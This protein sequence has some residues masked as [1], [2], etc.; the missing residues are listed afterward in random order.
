MDIGNSR[1]TNEIRYLSPVPSGVKRTKIYSL[2]ERVR[3]KYDLV[4]GFGQHDMIS[5][6]GGEIVYVDSCDEKQTDS[7]T[8]NPDD[9][10]T[11][12][13]ATLCQG[14]YRENFAIAREIG[15]LMLHWPNMKK[16]NPEHGMRITREVDWNNTD[17][18]QAIQEANWFALSF[19]M[20]EEDFREAYFQRIASVKFAVAN[21]MVEKRAR[22]LGIPA[23][24]D[25]QFS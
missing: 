9:S 23:N 2:G 7:L 19:L 6:L 25:P 22:Y 14:G 11:I 4:D 8:V 21:D 13:L 5:G 18:V 3:E 17:L 16:D 1:A 24:D 20:P 15:H 12:S 10:F